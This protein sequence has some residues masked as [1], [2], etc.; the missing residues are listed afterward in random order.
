HAVCPRYGTGAG[1][2]IR[3]NVRQSLHRGL[4]GAGP[5]SRAK[6]A[7]HGARGRAHSAPRF[8]RVCIVKTLVILLFLPGLLLSQISTADTKQRQKMVRDLAKDGDQAIPKIAPYV[9]DPDLGV[10]IESVKSLDAI[11]GPKTVDLLVQAARDN[12]PEM[13]VRATDGL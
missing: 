11:G 5:E 6:A 12:D 13:Q 10:R 7:R 1:R 8:T 9:R 2:K 3:G 4:R